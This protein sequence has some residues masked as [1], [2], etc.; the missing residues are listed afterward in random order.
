MPSHWI[1]NKN[2]CNVGLII[3][4][5]QSKNFTFGHIQFNHYIKKKGFL[6]VVGK[7]TER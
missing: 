3:S 5:L 1:E 7:E 6:K 4:R 2:Q